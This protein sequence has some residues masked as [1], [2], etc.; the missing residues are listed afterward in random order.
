MSGPF[1]SPI[2]AWILG[3]IGA[4]ATLL[5][6]G[7][8]VLLGALAIDKHLSPAQLGLFGSAAFLGQ[9]VAL[10]S[11]FFWIH[12]V[13]WRGLT[14]IFAVGAIGACV[15]MALASG[16]GPLTISSFALGALM[17]AFYAT[18]LSYWG[19][20]GD[21]TRAISIGILMQVLVASAFLYIV[22]A[23]L[24]PRWGMRGAVLLI[25]VAIV[26]IFPLSRSIPSRAAAFAGISH[27]AREIF[28]QA[29]A[30]AGLSIMAFYYVGVFAI[31][32]FL[33]RIGAGSGLD[34][35]DI[36]I[37]FGV[38]ML[39]GAL[40]L[41]FTGAV[42]ERI[43][44]FIPL[45][46]SL[47]LYG[48]FFALLLRPQNVWLYTLAL[49]FFNFAWNL[50]L[51]YQIS[52]IARADETGRLIVLLPAFQAAGASAGPALAGA[53]TGEGNFTAVYVLLG[54]CAVTAFVGFSALAL[55]ASRDCEEKRSPK[56]H[57]IAS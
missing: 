53:V 49:I 34:Q 30:L 20:A 57:S 46:V 43:G 35:T 10:A 3:Y 16:P 23:L 56:S 40:A 11:S 8:P 4:V 33:D 7:M 13:N 2:Q 50:G 45:A 37:A 26:P 25:V 9:L 51:P 31:W 1:R 36:G 28:K 47:G 6:N 22:P 18:V 38:S 5:A 42:G 39:I 19:S 48:A 32:A 14:Q 15:L 27:S 44:R 52:I 29:R 24:T 12:R 21:P 41:A 17:G 54:I 55:A